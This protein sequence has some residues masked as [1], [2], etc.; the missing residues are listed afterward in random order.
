MERSLTR[1]CSSITWGAVAQNTCP[2]PSTSITERGRDP[3]CVSWK[4]SPGDSASSFRLST[5]ANEPYLKAQVTQ[6][7]LLLLKWTTFRKTSNVACQDGTQSPEMKKATPEKRRWDNRRASGFSSHPRKEHQRGRLQGVK[8]LNMQL[9]SL[10]FNLTC[11]VTK[12][13][14]SDNF[15]IERGKRDLFYIFKI[16]YNE[17]Y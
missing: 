1:V 15:L 4:S 16:I 13:L 12:L 2:A 14:L 11:Q 7:N 3:G 6:Q 5:Q 8:W 17:H 9:T 10:L